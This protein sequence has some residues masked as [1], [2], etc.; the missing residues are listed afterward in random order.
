M[1]YLFIFL[2]ATVYIY[3]GILI[4]NN[5]QFHLIMFVWVHA[6]FY[7]TKKAHDFMCIIVSLDENNQIQKFAYQV[8][9]IAKTETSWHLHDLNSCSRNSSPQ[10]LRL[11]NRTSS[12]KHPSKQPNP[13]E[14]GRSHKTRT[15]KVDPHPFF[16]L[17][18]RKIRDRNLPTLIGA[19]H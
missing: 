13:Y 3:Q 4:Q 1:L 12:T 8:I 14:S 2:H 15:T 16:T 9:R 10:L 18:P 5:Y 11:P 6:C 19:V 17:M 7:S